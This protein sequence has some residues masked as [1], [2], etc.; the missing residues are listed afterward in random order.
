MPEEEPLL[1]AT[2]AGPSLLWK[3]VSFYPAADPIEYA[4]RKARVF[5]P[6]PNTLYFVPSVGLGYGLAEML[7]RLPAGSAILCV[8]CSQEIMGCAIARGLPRDPRLLVVRTS[9]PS[10]VREALRS[11]GVP[12][13]RRVIEVP[14]CAGYRLSPA[15]YAR[16]RVVLEEEVRR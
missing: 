6:L 5:S 12:S 11:L 16:L 9:E 15:L 8:E 1:V 2:D 10:G 13:F 3:G 4:R 14:L 7:D